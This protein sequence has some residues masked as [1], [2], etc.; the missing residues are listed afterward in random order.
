[1]FTR[2]KAVASPHISHLNCL[3]LNDNIEMII[4][5]K[6]AEIIYSILMTVTVPLAGLIV[7]DMRGICM[8]ADLIGG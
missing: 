6:T 3:N 8:K 4:G 2:Q 7:M 5:V 1:M